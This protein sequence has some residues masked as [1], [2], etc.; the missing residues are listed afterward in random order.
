MRR[1]ERVTVQGPVKEQQPDGMSHGGVTPSF[2]CIPPPSHARA[3]VPP[4]HDF[5]ALFDEATL[6]RGPVPVVP[7]TEYKASGL[8][9]ADEGCLLPT[10]SLHC[11]CRRPAPAA[12]RPAHRTLLLNAKDLFNDVHDLRLHDPAGPPRFGLSFRRA[13]CMFPWLAPERGIAA[14][15][16]RF[17]A[18]ALPTE[19]FAVHLRP[20]HF[21]QVGLPFHVCCVCFLSLLAFFF[22]LLFHAFDLFFL[23][24]STHLMP[25]CNDVHQGLPPI[26]TPGSP[27]TNISKYVR[28]LIF[29]NQRTSIPNIS[30]YFRITGL[31]D[32]GD[33]G[34]HD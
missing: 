29:T 18:A 20:F 23:F 33:F 24:F 25:L 30:E 5:F 31:R 9:P 2:Q 10:H 21:G 11:S 26:R 34:F 28:I 12:Q 4:Q 7:V 15:A 32:L 27:G 1:E 19:F 17:A 3:L 14:E 16:A 8:R 13:R 22:F 6:R